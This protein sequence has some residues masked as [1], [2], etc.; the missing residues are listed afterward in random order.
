MKRYLVL[1]LLLACMLLSVVG[2]GNLCPP[3]PGG[4]GY[5]MHYGFGYGAPYLGTIFLIVICLAI[6]F[7]IRAWKKKGPP[8]QQE[9]PLD[10]LKRRYANGEIAKE[11][12]ER[13]KKDLEG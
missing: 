5:M 8:P 3:G 7:I 4:G 9:S 11:E 10:V 1:S 6:Y 12:F 2:C 13:M